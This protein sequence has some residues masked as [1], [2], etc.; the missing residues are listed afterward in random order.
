MDEKFLLEFG[1]AKANSLR[2]V[3]SRGF[4]VR[5]PMEPMLE[6][7][8]L[9]TSAKQRG[10][11]LAEA[12]TETFAGSAGKRITTVFLDRNFD[13]VR[14]KD[15]MMSTDQIKCALEKHGRDIVLIV[16]FK[17]SAMARKEVVGVELFT[18]DDLAINIPEHVLYVAHTLD[19]H[20]DATQLPRISL[21]DPVVRWFAFPQDSVVRIDRPDGPT[22]RYVQ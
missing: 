9:Y 22:Y 18:F 2:M 3:A 21:T 6:M 8:K 10:V 20:P 11:S 14:R 4:N 13:T 12:A 19:E 5:K 7:S 17:P 1:L 15:K 16:P